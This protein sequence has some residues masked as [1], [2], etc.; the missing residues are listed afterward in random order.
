MAGFRTPDDVIFL[1]DCL[2]SKETLDKYRIGFI[3]DVAEYLK[4]LE[5]VKTLKA[6]TFVPAHAPAADDISELADYNIQKV[7]EVA[8]KI[9]EICKE[10]ICFELV[11]QKLFNDYGLTM[12]FEQYVLVGSTV[13]SYLSWLKDGG[14]LN[15]RFENNMLMWIADSQ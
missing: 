14:R 2:S 5:T 10:P 4:T 9:V 8:E 11:L 3:Y 12:N 13:R 15:T 1:A 6:K 7:N